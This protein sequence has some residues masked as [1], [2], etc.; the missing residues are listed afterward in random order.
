MDDTINQNRLHYLLL[1][2]SLGV[3]LGQASS[4]DAGMPSATGAELRIHDFCCGGC[5]TTNAG[6][7]AKRVWPENAIVKSQ[8]QERDI[9]RHMPLANLH[10]RKRAYFITSRMGRISFAYGTSRPLANMWRR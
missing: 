8:K 4:G 7:D 9:P 5:S 3:G 6:G 1:C 2:Y 10:Q